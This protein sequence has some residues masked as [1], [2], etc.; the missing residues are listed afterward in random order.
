MQQLSHSEACDASEEPQTVPEAAAQE[1]NVVG[2]EGRTGLQRALEMTLGEFPSWCS[3]N[4][5]E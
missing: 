1:G 3:G 4:K 2:K 5:S